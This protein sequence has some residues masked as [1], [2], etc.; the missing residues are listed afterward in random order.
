MK[1][2]SCIDILINWVYHG[3]E[4]HIGVTMITVRLPL[5]SL[6]STLHIRAKGVKAYAFRC[7]QFI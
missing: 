6:A 5:I 7:D 1:N 3:W 2:E 4:G